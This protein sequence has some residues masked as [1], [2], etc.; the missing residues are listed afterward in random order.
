MKILKFTLIVSLVALFVSNVSYAQTEKEVTKEL[1]SKALKGARKEAKEMER[2]GHYIAPGALPLERQLEGAWIKQ[3]QNDESGYPLYIVA[4]GNGVAETQ[5]AAKL[6]ATEMAKFELAG[7]I[8][9]NV[10]ALIESNIGN[11]QLNAEEATS[12]TEI[13]GAIKN[14]IAQEIGRVI[15]LVETYKKV[16]KGIEANVRV[17]YNSEIAKE[18]AKKVLREE[19]KERTKIQHEKLEKL[20]NF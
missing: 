20:M 15:P 12:V 2:D 16:G 17:A 3:M 7:T 10:A 19:L 9:T 6:Q 5:T 18:A 8:Q 1:K 4:T 13:S 11:A 14:I